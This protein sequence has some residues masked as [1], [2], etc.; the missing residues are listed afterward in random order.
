[1]LAAESPE[2]ATGLLL[3]SYPLHPPKKPDQTRTG[4]FADWRTQRY[5]SMGQK[6]LL[7]PLPENEQAL[8]FIPARTCLVPIEGAGHD[9]AGGIFDI[10]S[11]IFNL[12]KLAE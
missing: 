5:L 1:M 6:I 12:T 9:L 3:L 10:E 8:K 2:V 11:I 7:G 4:H